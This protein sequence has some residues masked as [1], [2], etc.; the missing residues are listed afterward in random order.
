MQVNESGSTWKKILIEMLSL[1]CHRGL[2]ALKFIYL[3]CMWQLIRKTLKNASLPRARHWIHQKRRLVTL[4]NIFLYVTRD[5]VAKVNS[6]ELRIADFR[7]MELTFVQKIVSN[8]PFMFDWPWMTLRRSAY[9][10]KPPC[11]FSLYY[12]ANLS[13]WILVRQTIYIQI[14]KM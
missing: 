5:I 9:T 12:N 6:S 3:I 1:W 11:W 8:D 4:K 13:T 2:I 7:K 10:R 14:I